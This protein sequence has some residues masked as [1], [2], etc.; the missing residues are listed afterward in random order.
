MR[1]SKMIIIILC[2]PCICFARDSSALKLLK[3]APAIK[4]YRENQK[5]EKEESGKFC[6]KDL[7]KGKNSNKMEREKP[8]SKSKFEMQFANKKRLGRKI[9]GG[10]SI[11]KT[12]GW[13]VTSTLETAEKI[14]VKNTSSASIEIVGDITI[15]TNTVWDQDVHIDGR[16]TVENAMLC[17]LP[18][19][20]VSF[21]GGA[22][23][24]KVRNNGLI[25][26]EGTPDDCVMFISDAQ[27]SPQDYDC[28]IKIEASASPECRINYCYILFA[29]KG[30][31][32]EGIRLNHPLFGNKIQ[33]CY[34]GVFQQGPFLTDIINNRIIDCY[35]D[36][37]EVYMESYDPYAPPTTET[38]ITIEQN[39]IVGDFYYGW[40]QDCGIRIHG[41]QDFNDVGTV[42]MGNN[43]I[44][45]SY[46][47]ALNQVDGYML[48]ADR[49]CHGYYGNYAIEN[50][51]NPFS[52]VYPQI[53]EEDPFVYGYTTSPF[54]LLQDCN[55][56]DTGYVNSSIPDDAPYLLG[57][58]TSI[59]GTADSNV[60]DIGFHYSNW[61]YSNAGD[62]NLSA[63]FDCSYSIG[64]NDLLFFLD[65]WLYD[66][67][68]NYER[69]WWDFD[70]SG[71]VDYNDL[72]V[73]ADYWLS[74][75]DFYGFAD[76]ALHWQR[77]VDYRFQDSRPDLNED[78]FIDFVDF[79][80]FASQ[81]KQIGDLEPNI[82]IQ[83]YG[84]SNDGYVDV[85]VSGF[86]SDTLRV[87]LLVDGQYIDEMLWFKEGAPF[88][89][90]ISALGP[91]VHQ[92]KVV[93]I[94]TTD[95]VTCSNLK[96]STFNCFL[97][98]C[99][100]SDAYDS[101]EPH[102]FCAYYSGL[103]DISVKVY[104]EEEDLVWSQTYTA[105]N[106]CD[107]IPANITSGDDLDSIVFEEVPSGGMMTL[108]SSGSGSV[109]K[110]LGLKF[111]PEKVPENIRALLILPY[112]WV[113]LFNDVEDEVKKTFK[114][115][116]VPYCRLKGSNAT[117]KN[118]AWLARNR[119]I[120]YL[121]YAGHGN[122]G[123]D[124]KTGDYYFGDGILR[125]EIGLYKGKAVS[126]K[127]SDFPGGTAPSWCQPLPGS[128][129]RTRYSIYNLGFPPGQLKFVQFDCC[130]SGRLRLTS[131]GNLVES[132]GTI[133]GILAGPESDMSWAL[134]LTG[135]IGG[136]YYQGWWKEAEV[137]PGKSI[138]E[139]FS[140]LE[141][142]ELK[143]GENLYQAVYY[144]SQEAPFEA[145][146]DFR[147][148]G[149][150]DMTAVKI[151]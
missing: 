6:P 89:L 108:S 19:V 131:S 120:E 27:S 55:L 111:N 31:W 67:Q 112:G 70:D 51:G 84:D 3:K 56:I 88:L 37:I 52:D 24:I 116:H 23:W 65:Y 66:Y 49:Y 97:N 130:F 35:S 22:N 53:L 110:S 100:C 78:G 46:F 107:F 137:K 150:G 61:N 69:W 5:A 29:E 32:I 95:K 75:F 50:P 10:K 7:E 68:E 41:V 106:L 11:D 103:N 12:I 148:Y 28:A 113:N 136:K 21:A 87:F 25:I 128:L 138:Y 83:I 4:Q 15:N 36:G 135:G 42:L 47:Y 122:Y 57:T 80:M 13:E 94:S 133:D 125:T 1:K 151:E 143:E 109:A 58:T 38:H 18:E 72:A 139:I 141:W 44:A 117:Y 63:D 48:E 45:A 105:E 93:S 140:V 64:P 73:I 104:N 149:L 124:P 9:I 115:R 121:Y 30:T 126:A 99:F 16:V 102:H 54:C 118:F 119:N 132:P 59:D 146:R 123:I 76:F 17:I 134:R 92:L 20:T 71:A 81:W 74:Y 77:D 101:N 43:I 90:D 98:S 91:G 85:G 127:Y 8:V 145:V 144:A 82:Q 26:A 14:S 40:G 79:S 96:E 39:T 147:M 60:A 142:A 34:D 114:T 33:Y 129:E 2:F 86:T 62:T